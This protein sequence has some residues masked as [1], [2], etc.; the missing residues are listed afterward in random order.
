MIEGN[1]KWVVTVKL[2]GES[3]RLKNDPFEKETEKKKNCMQGRNTQTNK[4]S[5]EG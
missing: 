1:G 4:S 5:K 2:A 3:V